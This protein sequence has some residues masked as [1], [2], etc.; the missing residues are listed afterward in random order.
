[1]CVARS[2]PLNMLSLFC[3]VS[4]RR[5]CGV[6]SERR[7]RS[8]LAHAREAVRIPLLRL[9][10]DGNP[11]WTSGK[12]H[13]TPPWRCS[14]APSTRRAAFPGPLRTARLKTRPRAPAPA[15][16]RLGLA[17]PG[18]SAQQP[19]ARSPSRP[20]RAPSQ[21]L[22]SRR[23]ARA[24]APRTRL[25]LN[26]QSL[27]IF[28]LV[29]TSIH[30]QTLEIRVMLKAPAALATSDRC[31]IG[32][33]GKMDK[34]YSALRLSGSIFFCRISSHKYLSPISRRFRHRNRPFQWPNHLFQSSC[35]SKTC[36]RASPQSS[37]GF[38]TSLQGKD[39]AAVGQRGGMHPC[40]R[41]ASTIP[42]PR[43]AS[44]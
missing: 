39:Q 7:P 8:E 28:R 26:G 21:A 34:G 25:E 12:S 19:A 20:A 44:A 31:F 6:P 38:T 23:R 17:R 14:K 32:Y 22:A 36:H 29:S 27:G 2:G 10:P 41:G 11:A 40:P 15:A 42:T 33:P 16:E 30:L 43:L 3:H 18:P 35:S 24:R 9:V 5:C 1:M 37:L 4:G 13:G